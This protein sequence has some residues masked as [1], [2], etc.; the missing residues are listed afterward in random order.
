PLLAQAE[1]LDERAVRL[2]VAALEVVQE[3]AALADELQQPAARME[4]LDVRL[5]MVG[6][7]VDALGEE[8][9]LDLGRSGV[10]LGALVLG[11]VARRVCGGC[12]HGKNSPFS[13]SSGALR[14]E[15]AILT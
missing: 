1:A 2:D 12:A 8:R 3:A 4:I 13:D 15:Q 9:H 11:N 14:V 6:E 10:V 7:H 5:E